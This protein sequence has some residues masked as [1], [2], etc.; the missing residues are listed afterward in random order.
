LSCPIRAVS[1]TLHS[2]HLKSTVVT[3]CTRGKLRDR[4]ESEIGRLRKRKR[5]KAPCAD[6]LIPVHSRQIRL[7][8]C[9]SADVLCVEASRSSQLMFQTNTPLHEVRRVKFSVGYG[10]DGERKKTSGRIR[11]CRRAGKLALCKSRTERLIGG[12]G[13]VNHT[14]RNSRRNCCAAN[15]SKKSA[16]KRFDVGRIDANHIGDGTGQYVTEN[17]EPSTQH[18]LGFKLPGDGRSGLQDREGR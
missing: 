10:R 7:V 12:Y 18:G 8:H 6:V 15:G 3:V 2:G 1:K 5:R 9:T 17:P 16:L 11:L 14:V 4:T 13:C